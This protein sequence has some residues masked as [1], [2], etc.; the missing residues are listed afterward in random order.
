[1][2]VCV[3][4][5]V[6]WISEE[7][8][9][10]NKRTKSGKAWKGGNKIMNIALGCKIHNNNNTNNDWAI[11]RSVDI[12]STGLFIERFSFT[13]PVIHILQFLSSSGSLLFF[14]SFY[15]LQ[16]LFSVKRRHAYYVHFPKSFTSFTL[17]SPSS[18]LSFFLLPFCMCLC[19][20]LCLCLCPY[21]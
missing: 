9:G 10:E 2:Y 17:F 18:N 3:C 14:Y 15:S 7:K 20:C 21:I 1:M 13:S 8:R 16:S 6:K 12:W 5:R 4:M 19:V 11:H